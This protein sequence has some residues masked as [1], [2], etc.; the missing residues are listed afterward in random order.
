MNKTLR[1][2]VT[3]LSVIG[4]YASIVSLSDPASLFGSGMVARCSDYLLVTF[5]VA[6]FI[7]TWA[8][9]CIARL[10]GKYIVLLLLLS[11]SYSVWE[12]FVEGWLDMEYTIQLALLWATFGI[13]AFLYLFFDISPLDL[14]KL[15]NKTEQDS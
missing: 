5:F 9:K 8:P 14:N 15:K 11:L 1:I 13:M 3:I 2:I 4:F 10:S 6:L 7:A 12:G